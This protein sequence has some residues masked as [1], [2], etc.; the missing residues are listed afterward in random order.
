MK[1]ERLF[2]YKVFLSF[3]TRGM[4]MKGTSAEFVLST[5]REL[6]MPREIT[7]FLSS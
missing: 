1:L 3:N 4:T 2:V 7:T 6:N 5:P